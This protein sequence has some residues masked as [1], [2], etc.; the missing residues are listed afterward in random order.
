MQVEGYF[1]EIPWH[2]TFTYLHC[3]GT[4]CWLCHC[5]QFTVL[6]CF[7]LIEH[8]KSEFKL[9]LFFYHLLRV[10]TAYIYIIL[11]NII[12]KYISFDNIS[13]ASIFAF[14]KFDR[15]NSLGRVAESLVVVFVEDLGLRLIY[16]FCT[17]HLAHY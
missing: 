13:A 3:K 2:K 17:L 8:F 7:I 9:R 6:L 10:C 12:W 14:L 1:W 15:N 4:P 11:L 16:L 5:G